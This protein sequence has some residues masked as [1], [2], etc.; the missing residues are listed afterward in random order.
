[1]VTYKELI[2][3]I[4]QFMRLNKWTF[5]AIFCLDLLLWPVD[6]MI[7]PYILHLVIDVFTHY[8][9]D[10]IAAWDALKTPIIIGVSFVIYMEIGSRTMGFLQA[11]A[12]PKLQAHLRMAMFDHVQRHS[13]RYFNEQ[14]AGSLANKITDMTMQVESIIQQ[15]VWPLRTYHQ[16]LSALRPTNV[17]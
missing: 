6:A 8:E 12:F 16:L 3:F 17:T 9:G 2:C 4:W 10:R 5:I 1:M 15:L 14:F 7:W 11:K 13:P